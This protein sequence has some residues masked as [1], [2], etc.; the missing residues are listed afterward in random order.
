[1]INLSVEI[2]WAEQQ[3]LFAGAIVECY[4]ERITVMNKRTV[5]PAAADSDGFEDFAGSI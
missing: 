1:M 4:G 3:L 5:F 2:T